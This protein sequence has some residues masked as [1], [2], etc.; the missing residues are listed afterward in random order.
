MLWRRIGLLLLPA[1]FVSG[2]VLN[3]QSH[4]D[5][6]PFNRRNNF[7]VF[8]EYSNDSS[9]MLL[10]AAEQRKLLNF[11]FSYSRRL[12]AGR[13]VDFQ[14]LVE[15]RPVILESDPVTHYSTKET[16]TLQGQPPETFRTQ[17]NYATIQACQPSTLTITRPIEGPD[18]G[19]DVFTATY[20]CGAR[21]WTFGQGMSPVGIKLNFL[22]RHRLQPVFTGLGGYMFST[23]PIPVS[24]AGSFNFT[25]E[26][27]AGL[28]F[29]RS[30]RSSTS[31]FG[32]RSWRAE[33]R[34]HHISNHDTATEN[35]G[36]DSGTL[37]VTY[38]FG[39]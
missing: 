11:G 22:P 12:V 28:E 34:Y 30:R 2:N 36:I 4:S 13:F 24:D 27:G 23:E 21:K 20:T 38:A 18:P 3:A 31:L 35:P 8:G 19:T 14:Y 32:N 15:L 37:Q 26:F 25:F 29:Y 16:V 1:A 33:Y 39:R 6:A 10:G 5:G 7:G 9:H 17:G